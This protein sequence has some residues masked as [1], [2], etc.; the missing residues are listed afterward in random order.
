MSKCTC[1]LSERKIWQKMN[2]ARLQ[3][4]PPH[5]APQKGE[6]TLFSNRLL[7][8]LSRIS[9]QTVLAVYLPMIVLAIWKSYEVSVST[10]VFVMLFLT[11]VVFW[12]LFEYVLHR[13]VF[14]FF[15]EGEFQFQ[16]WRLL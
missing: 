1:V 11:G 14:H 2:K 7:E 13:Y 4:I 16:I 10:S 6:I 15:P 12:T 8:R 3:R 5:L 9:P